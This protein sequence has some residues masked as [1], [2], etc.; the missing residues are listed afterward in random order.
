MAPANSKFGSSSLQMSAEKLS[1]PKVFGAA[2]IA[3]SMLSMP[4]FA[5]EGEYK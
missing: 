2:L 5:V 3:S 1:M 4:V